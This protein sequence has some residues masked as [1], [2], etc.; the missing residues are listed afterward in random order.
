MASLPISDETLERLR[1][2][3]KTVGRPADDLADQVLSAYLDDVQID[4]DAIEEIWKS[5][6]ARQPADPHDVTADELA[7]FL[8]SGDAEKRAV[9]EAHFAALVADMDSGRGVTTTP[10]GAMATIR[11][12]L[13]L[14]PA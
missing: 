3:A 11:A 6:R 7:A 8:H 2:H 5:Y 13:G 12:R 14:P 1:A 4:D 9:V 10:E